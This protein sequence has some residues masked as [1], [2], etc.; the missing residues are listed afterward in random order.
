MFILSIGFIEHLKKLRVKCDEPKIDFFIIPTLST[1]PSFRIPVILKITEISFIKC[2]NTIIITITDGES[3]I[4]TL[5]D[6]ALWDVLD[7]RILNDFLVPK[8]IVRHGLKYYLEIGSVFILNQ[9]S[10]KE[11]Q[12]ESECIYMI[13]LKSLSLIGYE[14]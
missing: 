11:I 7:Q 10:F 13:N 8:L 5:L 2:K 14:D 3:I 1:E 12:L 9:Y 6:K 4:E